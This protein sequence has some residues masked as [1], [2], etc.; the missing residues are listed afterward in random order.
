[1]PWSSGRWHRPLGQRWW[2]SW[3]HLCQRMLWLFKKDHF[4]LV[5]YW[6]CFLFSPL[7]SCRSRQATTATSTKSSSTRSLG[8]R[9]LTERLSTAS[10]KTCSET[11]PLSTRGWAAPWVADSSM[12][13][14]LRRPQIDQRYSVLP[15]E[16]FS[17]QA[18][19][20]QTRE[21]DSVLKLESQ[22]LKNLSFFKKVLMY[23]IP[24]K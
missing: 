5:L 2:V 11:F 7:L 16:S 21:V 19:W 23:N 24:L 3:L 22:K 12:T 1:M 14:T 9:P 6:T 10:T 18:G 20:R 17:F 8:C 15:L 4:T 13:N